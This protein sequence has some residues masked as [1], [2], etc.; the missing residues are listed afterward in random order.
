MWVEPQFVLMLVPSGDALSMCTSAPRRVN[1][2]SAVVE[3]LPFAQSSTTRMP[4]QSVC[5]QDAR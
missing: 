4:E 2:D 5:T 3:E 1:R